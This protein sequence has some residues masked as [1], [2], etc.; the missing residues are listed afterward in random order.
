[1]LTFKRKLD[2]LTVATSNATRLSPDAFCVI[3]DGK[4]V[5]LNE[6]LVET[7]RM[8]ASEL[9]G[10]DASQFSPDT[11]PGGESS[12]DLLAGYFA[13][14]VSEGHCRF[15]WRVSRPDGSVFDV[16]STLMLFDFDGTSHAIF[17]WQNIDETIRLRNEDAINRRKILA[18]ATDSSNAVSNCGKALKQ[19]SQGALHYRIHEDFAPEYENLRNDFNIAVDRLDSTFHQ[20]KSS[21][22]TVEKCAKL[23]V[24]GADQLSRGSEQQAA[25]IEEA[26]AALHQTTEN[27]AN[28]AVATKTAYRTAETVMTNVGKVAEISESL[29]VAMKRIEEKSFEIADI[30]TLIDKIALQTNLLALNAGVEAARA[31]EAGR[32]FAV[33]AQEVRDLARHSV[34]A[35]K[36]IETRIRQSSEAVA[37]GTSLFNETRIAL[38]TIRLEISAISSQIQMLA[39]AS[40]EQADALKEISS[41]I[42][43]IDSSS[44]QNAAMAENSRS[45]AEELFKEVTSLSSS[46]MNFTTTSSLSMVPNPRPE[47]VSIQSYR[48]GYRL[49]G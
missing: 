30:T 19:L 10:A 40:N 12:G 2:L 42:H 9:M 43:H 34:A 44:Q 45:T 26:A 32:G 49:N 35:A 25:S 8:S 6:A 39:S 17:V 18:A 29:S 46:A 5:A 21:I 36:E 47:L 20:V 15:E 4:I 41:A 13:T 14:A 24:N 48:Q 22:S 7:M 23:I 11:Q 1:M 28:M 38:D 27:I 37:S 3:R 33:V 31:G 16:F